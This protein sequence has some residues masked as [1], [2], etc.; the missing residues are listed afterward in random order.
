MSA[1]QEAPQEKPQEKPQAEPWE[2][3]EGEP[4]RWYDR[5]HRFLLLGAG[6]SLL[7]V[8][9]EDHR[10]RWEA[11]Q[12]RQGF[13]GARKGAKGRDE[14]DFSDKASEAPP[15][16]YKPPSSL[17]RSWQENAA[18]WAWRERAALWDEDER[19]RAREAWRARQEA[20]R[21]AEWE[22]H[23]RLI[24]K[25]RAMAAF[26]LVEE[27]VEEHMDEE[28]RRVEVRVTTPAA[29]RLRDAARLAK[30]A[31]ELGR[32]ATGMETERHAVRLGD[33]SAYTD[34]ELQ[35]IRD[36]E[37]PRSVAGEE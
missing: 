14:K 26:P 17:A 25:A 18:A 36:G 32:L 22:L 31:S 15:G 21:R 1:K 8:Y 13:K 23:E 29:W 2:R 6:R 30:V 10:A 35:R 4:K 34:E 16:E 28:G 7:A 11:R 19:T 12:T 33:L 3:Q 24:E 20:V 9:R 5:F 27:T 37:D